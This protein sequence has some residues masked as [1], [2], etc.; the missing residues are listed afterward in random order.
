MLRAQLCATLWWRMANG[1]RVDK[2]SIFF[3]FW[4]KRATYWIAKSMRV[5]FFLPNMWNKNE[6]EKKKNEWRNLICPLGNFLLLSVKHRA[7][8]GKLCEWNTHSWMKQWSARGFEA[9]ML[10]SRIYSWMKWT[11]WLIAFSQHQAI[12]NIRPIFSPFLALLT[13]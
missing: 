1:K 11:Q 7:S 13:N 9:W 2:N 4:S 10:F 12:C 8:Y 3:L 5:I 6:N